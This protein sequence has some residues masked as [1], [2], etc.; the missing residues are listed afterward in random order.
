MPPISSSLDGIT[1]AL[2][3]SRQLDILAQLLLRRG[4]TILKVPMV[5]IYD[6]PDPEP[7]LQ[8]L[9]RFIA[10]T[11]AYMIVLTG[12][13]LRRLLGLADRHGLQETFIEAL[14]RS[15]LLCRGPKPE[16]VLRSL[17][18]RADIKA[19]APTTDGVIETLAAI[20]LEGESVGVQLYGDDPNTKLMAYLNDRRAQVD[21]VSPYIYADESESSQVVDLIKALAAKQVDAIAFTSQPQFRRLQQ[22][23]RKHDLEA[24][25]NSGLQATCIA[26]VGPVVKDQLEAAG[27]NVAIM[28]EKAYFMKPLV[29]EMMRYFSKD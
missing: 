3:E 7:V 22:V 8:W 19:V 10:D 12:E 4:A 25:L 13:G 18:M 14:K 17:G 6:A 26:A 11:P 24:E 23:A 9:E 1:V 5:S 15:T 16:R 2:P 29:T 21:K 20:A 28:P 27:H